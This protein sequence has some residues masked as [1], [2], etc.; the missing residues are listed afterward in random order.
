M[1]AA[2]SDRDRLVHVMLGESYAM[3]AEYLAACAVGDPLHAWLFSGSSYRHRTQKKKA[4]GELIEHIGLPAMTWALLAAFLQ[5]NF[6]VDRLGQKQVERILA[7]GPHTAEL[8][9]DPALVRRL[10]SALGGLMVMSREFRLDTSRLFLTS[11]GYPA[12]HPPRARPGSARHRG[13]RRRAARTPLHL[14][15]TLSL[16]TFERRTGLSRVAAAHP[17]APAAKPPNSVWSAASLALPLRS[18]GARCE[19]DRRARLVTC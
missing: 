19:F 17:H 12:R 13:A 14:V 2:L 18:I 3:A 10:R 5:N 6:L 8:A 15:G 4:V 1:R 9:H 7:L 11:L 16:H